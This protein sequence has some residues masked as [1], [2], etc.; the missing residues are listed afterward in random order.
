M[1]DHSISDFALYD[2]LPIPVSVVDYTGL[3]LYYNEAAAIAFDRKPEY[4]GQDIRRC[5]KQQSSIEK[6]D[7]L[8]K[9][10]REA[11]ILP[12]SYLVER[13]GKAYQVIIRRLDIRGE[14]VGIVQTAIPLT[15]ETPSR[16]Q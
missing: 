7:S 8:L 4:I 10:A 3:L 16:L 2:V 1:S 12:A 6:I 15:S 5:H 13:K 14:S 11:E 9:Q